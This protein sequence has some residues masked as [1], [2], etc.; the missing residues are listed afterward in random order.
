MRLPGRHGTVAQPI[1]IE[2]E[3]GVVCSIPN[4]VTR[5]AAHVKNTWYV[6]HRTDA[7]GRLALLSLLDGLL[8]PVDP[9]RNR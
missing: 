8:L 9:L 7:P 4:I 5:L 2:K 6:G 1:I 3:G